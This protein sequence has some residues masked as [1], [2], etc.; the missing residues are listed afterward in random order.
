MENK[1]NLTLRKIDFE[2]ELKCRGLIEDTY[3][4][5]YKMLGNKFF[6]FIYVPSYT[7]ERERLDLIINKLET[8]LEAKGFK[9]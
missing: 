1:Y 3:L 8:M 4:A 6:E 7:G 9:N 2:I 5:L